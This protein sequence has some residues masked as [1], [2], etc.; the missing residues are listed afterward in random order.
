M[1]PVVTLD[2][3]EFKPLVGELSLASEYVGMPAKLRVRSHKTGRSV[4]FHVVEPG[5]RLYD[6]DGW[7]GEMCVYRPAEADTPV[8]YLVIYHQY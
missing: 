3:C 6:E 8:K 1:I 5:D 7:D 4:M 2:K